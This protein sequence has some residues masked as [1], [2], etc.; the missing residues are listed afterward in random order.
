MKTT[1]KHLQEKERFVIESLW[2]AQTSIRG[3]ALILGRSPNTISREIKRRKI[4]QAEKAHH[5]AYLKRYRSKRM[6][7][8]VAMD[9]FLNRFVQEKIHEKWSPKQMS[10]YLKN[11]GIRVSSK[12]IYKFIG[13]RGLNHL[14]FWGRNQHKR[15]KKVYRY[16]Q[17]PDD[18]KYIEERPVLLGVGHY[19]MDFMVSRKSTWV[20]LVIVDRMSKQ[21]FVEKL[22]NRKRTTI[23]RALS[24]IFTGKPLRSITTDNDIAFS[25]WKQLEV[26]LDTQIFFCHPYHSWEKGLVENTN[27]WIREFVSNQRDMSTVT[28]QELVAIDRYL[29]WRPREIIGFRF[30]SEVYYQNVSVLLGG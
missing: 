27:R 18:R 10:G 2:R 22:P 30:P 8:K 12:A 6:C 3:I 20:L 1:Y 7:M 24:K 13:R 17:V 29:N 4:Y 5:H 25:G 16:H 28:D 9:V 19:E 21:T 14:L 26:L 15:G 23:H 11:Q